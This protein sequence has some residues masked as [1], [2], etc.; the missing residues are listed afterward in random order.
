MENE[1]ALREVS[2]KDHDNLTTLGK[3]GELPVRARVS[4]SIPDCD[5]ERN[6][7]PI[8]G[9]VETLETLFQEDL[10]RRVALGDLLDVVAYFFLHYFDLVEASF[11]SHLASLELPHIPDERGLSGLELRDVP[12]ER[13]LS[14]FEV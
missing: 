11:H 1:T 6:Q 2:Q 5:F 4:V 10:R 3:P 8:E 14:G 7:T 12:D 13:G 9:F